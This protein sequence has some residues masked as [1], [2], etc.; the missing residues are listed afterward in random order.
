MTSQNLT[1]KPKNTSKG[2]RISTNLLAVAATPKTGLVT[3]DPNPLHNTSIVFS[4]NIV[5]TFPTIK[6]SSTKTVTQT[7]PSG[8]KK[9]GQ[10]TSPSARLSIGYPQPHPSATTSPIPSLLTPAPKPHPTPSPT[11]G[12]KPTPPKNNGKDNTN[13]TSDPGDA[14]TGANFTDSDYKWNLPPHLW[15][16][17]ISLSSVDI[18]PNARERIIGATHGKNT[19]K[20]LRRGRIKWYANPNDAY[21]V[22]DGTNKGTTQQAAT[23]IERCF[24]FQFLWNPESFATQVTLNMDVTPSVADAYAGVALAFPSGE[25]IQF[26]L[27]IDRTNDFVTFGNMSSDDVYKT[28][29]SLFNN[30]YSGYD[31]APNLSKAPYAIRNLLQDLR[32]RGTLADIEFLYQAI[33]GPNSNWTPGNSQVSGWGKRGVTGQPTSDIGFL[34]STLLNIDI[35]PTSF[36]GFVDQLAINHTAFTEDMI[37]IRT[38]VQISMSLMATASFG[39]VAPTSA[40]PS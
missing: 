37:P 34:S 23:G 3:P 9:T 40:K 29:I 31:Y 32:L 27:R 20:D 35:G 11:P 12:P 13:Q 21:T 1:S 14:Q 39:S 30:Y 17:P 25:N 6:S 28:S 33:N 15:S 36:V 8:A 10:L 26:V 5:G 18:G 7:T 4:T 2:I 38:D 16:R 22:S 19:G 24:G